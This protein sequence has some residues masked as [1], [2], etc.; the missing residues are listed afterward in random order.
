VH[1]NGAGVPKKHE[2]SIWDRFERGAFTFM[3]DIQGSGLGLPITRGLVA[4]HHGRTGYR[5]S[6]HLGGACF[7]LTIP[8]SGTTSSPARSI[9]TWP[10]TDPP[11]L[12]DPPAHTPESI[13]GTASSISRPRRDPS[14]R[15]AGSIEDSLTQEHPTPRHG[16]STQ[17]LT[18]PQQALRHQVWLGCSGSGSRLRE[19][20]E[21]REHGLHGC[22]RLAGLRPQV[23]P[24]LCESDI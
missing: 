19:I 20:V 5:R 23:E 15:S 18:H 21:G 17:G 11:G 2:F 3:S 16:A 6:E 24:G 22:H 8:S 10:L 9:D 13:A 14:P 1:D 4:A 12:R 7:W